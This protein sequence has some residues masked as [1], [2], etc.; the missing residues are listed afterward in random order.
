MQN[1]IG[2]KFK[3]NKYGL[4]DQ[5]STVI[6]TGIQW[7]QVN[8]GYIP[9]MMVKSEKGIWYNHDEIIFLTII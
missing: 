2:F 4:T 9:Q 3:R 7:N 5:T 8:S 1:L 6:E